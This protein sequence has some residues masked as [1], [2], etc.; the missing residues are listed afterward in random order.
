MGGVDT[1][2][3]VDFEEGWR[4]GSRSSRWFRLMA[5]ISLAK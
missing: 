4:E 3:G 1:E 5:S 2:M